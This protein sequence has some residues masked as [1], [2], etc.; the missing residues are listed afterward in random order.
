MVAI[1]FPKHDEGEGLAFTR[2]YIMPPMYKLME[3]NLLFMNLATFEG[4]GDTDSFTYRTVDDAL[5]DDAK[6]EIPV[7][8]SMSADMPEVQISYGQTKSGSLSMKAVSFRMD[9][10]AVRRNQITDD[11]ARTIRRIGTWMAQDFNRQMGATLMANSTT[12]DWNPSAI[13]SADNAVPVKD[14]VSFTEKMM[15]ENRPYQ[16][17]DVYV[18]RANFAELR[19]YL[20]ESGMEFVRQTNYMGQPNMG[21]N[22]S[23]YIPMA[24]VNVHGVWRGVDEG[25]IMAV[26]ATQKPLSV[27]YY[28]DPKFSIPTFKYGPDKGTDQ[29][30]GGSTQSVPNFGFNMDVI[31]EPFSKD[32]VMQFWFDNAIV[33]KDQFATIVDTGI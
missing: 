2:E 19:A 29:G 23:I 31:E 12:P 4:V 6:K 25:T 20:A 5:G 21:T 22:M 13:W 1:P 7:I 16:A 3:Q 30:R 33:V 27:Y 28:N 8:F 10:R 17:T 11:I 15:S 9:R 18:N 24:G 26:D 14:I 32:M